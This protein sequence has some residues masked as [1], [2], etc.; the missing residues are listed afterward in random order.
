MEPKKTRTPRA[1]AK[2]ESDKS[3]SEQH[4]EARSQQLE[5][6]AHIT[7][8]LLAH[9][10]KRFSPEFIGDKINELLEATHLTKGGQEIADNRAREAG[11][12]LLMSYMV[13]LPV[14]RQEIVQFNFDSLDTLRERAKTS[15]ALR[16]ALAR[17]LE[18][19]P[20]DVQNAPPSIYPA[21]SE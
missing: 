4:L 2:K 13:G 14:Q 10:T 17:V 7:P 15:P 19:L 5:N 9:L 16:A 3:K 8:A 21:G 12:K 6:P 20:D 11:V 1:R 18:T